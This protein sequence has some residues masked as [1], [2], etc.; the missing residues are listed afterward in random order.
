MCIYYPYVLITGLFLENK[1]I[2]KEPGTDYENGSCKL[3]SNIQTRLQKMLGN[4]GV[5][6]KFHETL[7]NFSGNILPLR[8]YV[9]L[10]PRIQGQVEQ[11][12][13]SLF[14]TVKQ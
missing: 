10:L 11:H 5:S 12:R 14:R 13:L 2:G 4:V 6:H 3:E 8:N 7:M 9:M 1:V